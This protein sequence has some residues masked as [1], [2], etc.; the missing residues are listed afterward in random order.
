[1][2]PQDLITKANQE[3]KLAEERTLSLDK[4]RL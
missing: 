4:K 3:I 1:M 2:F